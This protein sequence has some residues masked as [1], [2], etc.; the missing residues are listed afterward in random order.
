VAVTTFANRLSS[1]READGTSAIC[2][3]RLTVVDF[4][5][6]VR[7]R[8][9]RRG[10]RVDDEGIVCGP[11]GR[12]VGAQVD[13]SDPLEKTRWMATFDRSHIDVINAGEATVADLIDLIDREIARVTR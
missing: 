8:I 13:F 12:T 9:E 1:P 2:G 11:L 5:R 6:V 10:L 3:E 7:E 4:Q